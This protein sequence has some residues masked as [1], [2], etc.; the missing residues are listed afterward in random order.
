MKQLLTEVQIENDDF[1][2]RLETTQQQTDS[3]KKEIYDL[4]NIVNEHKSEQLNELQHLQK[5]ALK[6][7]FCSSFFLFNVKLI[8]FLNLKSPFYYIN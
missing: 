6:Y 3:Y 1:K 5:Y 7:S 2:N 8:G 4:K